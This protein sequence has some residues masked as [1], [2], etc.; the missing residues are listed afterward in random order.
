MAIMTHYSEPGLERPTSA[1]STQV[2]YAAFSDC[3]LQVIGNEFSRKPMA[4]A[5]REGSYL[6]DPAI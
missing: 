6:R 2:K 3:D 4:I 5:V 1:D